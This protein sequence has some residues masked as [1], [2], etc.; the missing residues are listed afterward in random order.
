MS[1]KDDLDKFFTT[2][3]LFLISILFTLN[4]YYFNFSTYESINYKIK[5][6]EL[7]YL[8]IFQFTFFQ[9]IKIIIRKIS[10]LTIRRILEFFFKT[11]LLVIIIQ[12]CFYFYGNISLNDF[13]EK[14]LQN[15]NFDNNLLIKPL[16]ILLPYFISFLFIYFTENKNYSI[17]KFFK[18]TTVIF[19]FF[20]F[21]REIFLY[22]DSYLT[23]II[24]KKPIINQNS[25][26]KKNETTTLWVLFDEYDPNFIEDLKLNNNLRYF[27]HLKKESIYFN[28]IIPNAKQTKFSMMG[29]L[30]GF[31]FENIS[32]KNKEVFLLN[33][34][35]EKLKYDFN[36]TIFQKLASNQN[37]F[38]ILSTVTK[39]CSVYFKN[40]EL[41][42]C[43]EFVEKIN[44][45]D[46]LSLF[47]KK[48]FNGIFFHYSLINYVKNFYSLI[49]KDKKIKNVNN[50]KIYQEILSLQT[51]F[52]INDFDGKNFITFK[53]VKDLIDKKQHSLIFTHV[54][55]PHLPSDFSEKKF[56]YKLNK[57]ERYAKYLINLKYNDLIIK[58]LLKLQD[59]HENLNLII[60]S[61]HWF[62]EKDIKS[63]TY[64]E[65]LLAVK[66]DNE[67]DYYK[68]DTKYNASIVFHIIDSIINNKSYS[69]K[70]IID[71]ISSYEFANPCYNKN[72]LD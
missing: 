66:L 10:E 14:I 31:N 54:Y 29:I 13:L 51:D 52:D 44:F 43:Y 69:H 40:Y 61:D 25:N 49:S 18:I 28:N 38:A 35:N 70:K 58:K 15:L 5:I 45:F 16:K 19:L 68:I 53:K 65:S 50:K 21:Y 22:P 46:Q 33:N 26:I 34:K 11:W 48:N 37:N 30:T 9:L 2:K 60:S 62:R 55:L 32:I 8:L 57:N 71:D 72:C 1:F 24:D 59:E 4:Y 20:F 47:N 6:P 39:Y 64:Y 12:T 3:N 41:K 23:N 17:F 42:N 67:N 36:K 7:V 56:K 27:N 63:K